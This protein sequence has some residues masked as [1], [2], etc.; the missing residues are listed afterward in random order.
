MSESNNNFTKRELCKYSLADKDVIE[1]RKI[2]IL[3][4]IK[5]LGMDGLGKNK[6][7]TI[8]E[9]QEIIASKVCTSFKNRKIVNIMVLSKTQSGKTGSMCATIRRYLEDTSNLIPIENIFIITGLS[10]CEWKE[11]TK[12]R[13]PKSIEEN[14]YHRSDLKKKFTDKIKDNKNILIIMDEIQIASKE[15]QTIDNTF[16]ELGLLDKQKLYENDIKIIEYT[17]TPDGT[18]Y[19]LMKWNDASDKVLAEAG[20]R[21]ISSFDL[22]QM[23][24]VKQFKDLCGYNKKKD[25]VNEIVYE[26]ILEI[27]ND[28]NKFNDPM[29]HIIRTK[30]GEEADKTLENFKKKFDTDNYIF[31]TYDGDSNIDDINEKLIIKPGKHTFIFIKEMLRC[32]KTLKKK[33]LG[34]LYERFS[35]NISDSVVIQGLVGR[36]TGYDDNGL[37][38]CYTNIDSIERYEKLWQSD[39]DNK[40]ID[41]NS[42][43]YKSK[44]GKISSKK[45]FNCPKDYDNSSES[46]ANKEPIIEKFKT[47]KEV[48][49]FYNTELKERMGGRG[50][51]K[52]YPN[53]D[54]YFEA[55]IRTKGTRRYS[56]EEVYNERKM[57]LGSTEFRLYPCY[58]DTNDKSTLEFWL[59]YYE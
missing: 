19:D 1:N 7:L 18:I 43:T 3:S 23:Q 45:T 54:G 13:M 36:N 2:N 11:Q 10:S 42:K 5:Y 17:A 58:K 27:E 8:Y 25:E 28:I 59:I 4:D 16:E 30:K 24:R 9:N 38:I 31:I 47:Q 40:E 41:W 44:N 32:A 46:R 53:K 26:N 12:E 37:S 52:K 51:D 34:I 57:G 20:E 6:K 33:F 39:F 29:Y 56:F 35:T 21:Y 48:K 50:P 22:L 14:V 49:E 15:G 55:T